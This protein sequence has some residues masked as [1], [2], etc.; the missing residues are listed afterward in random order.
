MDASPTAHARGTSIGD[1]LLS[2]WGLLTKSPQLDQAGRHLINY[3]DAD[4][5]LR[6]PVE[7]LIAEAP[8]PLDAKTIN[9][10]LSLIQTLEPTGVRARN[11]GECLR[12][13]LDMLEEDE[14][15]AEGHDFDL[16]RT[17]RHA[18]PR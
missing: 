12:L 1:H 11:L 9:H 4:G 2:Q 14:E 6:T 13:Q 7:Q 18:P 8:F 3:I 16:Q 10:A 5:Y 15:L 17:P